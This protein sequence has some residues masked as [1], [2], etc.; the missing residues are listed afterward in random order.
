MGYNTTIGQFDAYTSGGWVS[1]L[2]SSSPQSQLPSNISGNG[3][4]LISGTAPGISVT[5][6]T[7]TTF[8]TYGAS[9]VD[10]ASAFNIANGRFTPQVAGYYLVNAWTGWDSNGISSG[11]ISTNIYKNGSAY[12]YSAI[13][14][15]STIYPKIE[16][17][18]LVPMN[19]TTDYITVAAFFIGS[20]TATN[21]YAQLQVV[22]IRAA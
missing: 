1:V 11:V 17:V 10:T 22:L 7:A 13:G 3:P 8:T 6:N 5:A 2:N 9:A 18:S 21:V 14:S 15:S 4:L 12:A 19:G 16:A 20:G